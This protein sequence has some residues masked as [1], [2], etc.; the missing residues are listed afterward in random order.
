MCAGRGKTKKKLFLRLTP[1]FSGF[2]DP[3]PAPTA[4]HPLP[5]MPR[6]PPT[7][8]PPLQLTA[9]EINAMISADLG[10]IDA[11]ALNLDAMEALVVRRGGR[12]CITIHDHHDL[13]ALAAAASEAAARG[14]SPSSR[15]RWRPRP[16]PQSKR[17]PS[18]GGRPRRRT[19]RRST[20]RQSRSRR[21]RQGTGVRRPLTT[22]TASPWAAQSTRKS[23]TAAG[24]GCAW[25]PKRSCLPC[26]G[27]RARASPRAPTR[28]REGRRWGAGFFLLVLWV[29][30]HRFNS[31]FCRGGGLCQHL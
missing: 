21:C 25:G 17:Q 26:R 15:A 16:T 13:N 3:P 30:A 24:G 9:D 6:R 20:P 7:P 8:P 10:A 31:L 14:A 18:A 28:R 29:T 23:G 27:C 4:P 11:H 5:T 12:V 1:A 19:R 2:A 22:P